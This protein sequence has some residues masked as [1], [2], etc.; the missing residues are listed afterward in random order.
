MTPCPL[1]LQLQDPG[2]EADI[3]LLLHGDGAQDT[4]ALAWPGDQIPPWDVHLLVTA[5][6]RI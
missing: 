3:C 2:P 6:L 5:K 1:T 4:L